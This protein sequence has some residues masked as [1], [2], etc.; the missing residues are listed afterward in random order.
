MAMLDV[1]EEQIWAMDGLSERVRQQLVIA[2]KAAVQAEHQV[3]K[4]PDARVAEFRRNG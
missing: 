2:L 1:Y 4:R 3:D